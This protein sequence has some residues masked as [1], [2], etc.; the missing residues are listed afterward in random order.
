MEALGG[1]QTLALTINVGSDSL[2]RTCSGT[3]TC[4]IDAD[5]AL[6]KR[7]L[8]G[9]ALINVRPRGDCFNVGPTR[10]TGPDPHS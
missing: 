5:A 3:R 8:F 9:C 7:R 10:R 1:E 2:V 4:V 6:P